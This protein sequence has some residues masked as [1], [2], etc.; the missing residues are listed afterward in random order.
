VTDQ[1]SAITVILQ[2]TTVTTDE[3]ISTPL[4]AWFVVKKAVGFKY[5]I[6]DSFF[7]INTWLFFWHAEVGRLLWYV[8]CRLVPNLRVDTISSLQLRRHSAL[9]LLV[10]RSRSTTLVLR[11][12]ISLSSKLSSEIS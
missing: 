11:Q 3:G 6:G 9:G 7:Q 8:T 5:D 10:S 12:V 4:L 1:R 2:S